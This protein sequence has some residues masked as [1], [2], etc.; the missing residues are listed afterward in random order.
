M[1]ASVLGQHWHWTPLV[2]QTTVLTDVHLRTSSVFQF[3]VLEY[4][5]LEDAVGADELESW[6]ALQLD[7][8]KCLH[9]LPN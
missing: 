4:Q 9:S 6:A 5:A 2:S 8:A 3:C 7:Y 1:D